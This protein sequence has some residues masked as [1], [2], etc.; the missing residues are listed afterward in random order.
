MSITFK[1]RR[2]WAS[3]CEKSE[4]RWMRAVASTP[5]PLDSVEGRYSYAFVEQVLDLPNNRSNAAIETGFLITRTLAARFVMSWQ[6]VHGGLRLGSPL[7]CH[8]TTGRGQHTERLFEH[9]RLLRDNNFRLGGGIAYSLPK[10]DLFASYLELLRGTDS[11]GGWAITFG[12][13]W[14][15]EVGGGGKP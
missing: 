6:R 14:P 4:S 13:S 8:R 7:G 1:A 12:V 11:H 9:D 10:I 3:G 15:F 2:H 5:S